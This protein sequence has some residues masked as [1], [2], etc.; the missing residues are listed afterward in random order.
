MGTRFGA[1]VGIWMN[2]NYLM[3]KGWLS[4]EAFNDRTWIVCQLVFFL[5]GAGLIAGVDGLLKDHLP[6]WLSGAD[7]ATESAAEAAPD[8]ALDPAL[9]H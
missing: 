1:L 6:R 9:S 5:T 8:H 7:A 4:N 3:M 2:L